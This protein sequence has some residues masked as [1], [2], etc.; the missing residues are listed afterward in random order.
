[1]RSNAKKENASTV[2]NTQG[3]LLSGDPGG[4]E[5]VL[6]SVPRMFFSK[7]RGSTTGVSVWRSRGAITPC[8]LLPSTFPAG[9]ERNH[10]QKS[11]PKVSY[12]KKCPPLPRPLGGV[13]VGAA[14]SRQSLAK[15]GPKPLA[16]DLLEMWAVVGTHTM[17]CDTACS[18]RQ[19]LPGARAGTPPWQVP[20]VRPQSCP[21]KLL[22][23]TQS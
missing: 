4:K 15:V 14:Q 5:F 17:V 1:M 18:S 2:R 19:G 21:L 20:P 11:I 16:L 6:R 22:A 10:N 23:T 8:C 7:K 3:E 9:R 13:G 12:R